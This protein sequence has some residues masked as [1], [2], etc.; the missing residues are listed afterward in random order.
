MSYCAF[1]AILGL[2]TSCVKGKDPPGDPNPSADADQPRFTLSSPAFRFGEAIPARYTADGIDVSPPFTWG[3]PPERTVAFALVMEDGDVPGDNWANW[4]VYDLPA[5]T[6]YLPEGI[7]A[8]TVLPVGAAEG[9]NAWG[10][11]GYRGPD[12]GPGEPHHY[13]I[14]LFALMESTGLEPGAALIDLQ[15][16]IYN[17]TIGQAFWMGTYGREP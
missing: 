6:V 11:I 13:D 15:D 12:P 4:V 17:S 7:G 16:A 2:A 3:S 14:T 8:G 1:V 10:T 9:A 5:D